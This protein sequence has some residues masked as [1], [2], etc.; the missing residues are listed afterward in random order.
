MTS[1]GNSYVNP[2]KWCLKSSD[3]VV[4]KGSCAC[5]RCCYE[6]NQ[7]NTSN[8]T[9]ETIHQITSDS[10]FLF[11]FLCIECYLVP[12]AEKLSKDTCDSDITPKLNFFHCYYQFDGCFNFGVKNS[13]FDATL[14]H[15]EDV[16]MTY[17]YYSMFRQ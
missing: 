9:H 13:P 11:L 16:T 1:H 8:T 15:A 6:G 10:L 12:L 4:I 17:R 5:C 3:I 7:W 2:F 14:S